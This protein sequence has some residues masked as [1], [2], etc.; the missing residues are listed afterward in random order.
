MVLQT[1]QGLLTA[2]VMASTLA[3]A[4]HHFNVS[5]LSSCCPQTAEAC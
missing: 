3:D 1:V 4:D 2:T 5:P